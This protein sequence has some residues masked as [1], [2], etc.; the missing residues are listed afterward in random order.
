METIKSLLDAAKEAKGVE[1][2]YALAKE[3]GLTK[4]QVSDYYKGKVVASEFACLRIA[5]ALGRNY[6]EIQAIVRI[7]AEKDETRREVWREYLKRL[8]GYAASIMLSLLTGLL[9]V[10]FIVTTTP[11]AHANTG[12]QKSSFTI[13][14][15]YAV[16]G[17]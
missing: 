10:T 9:F 4:Q 1:T 6:E 15:N 11:P 13:N 7:E 16:L 12:L 2:P 17:T 14:T 8:G 5:K 3:L